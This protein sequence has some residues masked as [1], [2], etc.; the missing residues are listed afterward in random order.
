[1]PLP[2]HEVY[3]GALDVSRFVHSV[4]NI[5]KNEARIYFQKRL[6]RESQLY[7]D[8][9]L[10]TKSMRSYPV[11]IRAGNR[12][13]MAYARI[14]FFGHG[15]HIYDPDGLR[16]KIQNL[17]EAI[18]NFGLSIAEIMTPA[19]ENVANAIAELGMSIEDLNDG[20]D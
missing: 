19:L 2:Y 17:S 7:E 13:V 10:L 4:N 12:L 6:K 9:R 3:I 1:M 16:S 20:E 11:F 14:E 8:L 18:N 5:S 15:V